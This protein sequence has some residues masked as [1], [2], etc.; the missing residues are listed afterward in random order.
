VPPTCD[1]TPVCAYAGEIGS[2]ADIVAVAEACATWGEAEIDSLRRR[3]PTFLV[4]QSFSVCPEDFSLPADCSSGTPLC[5][6]NLF[7][8]VDPELSG[9]DATAACSGAQFAAGSRF[10]ARFHIEPPRFGNQFRVAHIQF[11]RPCEAACVD[12]ESRCDANQNC[13][14]DSEVCFSCGRGTREECACRSPDNGILLDCTE[15][16]VRYD[17]A[18]LISQCIDGTCGEVDPCETCT[19][20]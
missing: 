13:Y 10:R 6:A 16:R 12:G 9:V 17:D 11:E 8:S 4:S 14:L 19:C 18:I 5:R 2:V 1:E 20:N 3:T 15:C 7:I